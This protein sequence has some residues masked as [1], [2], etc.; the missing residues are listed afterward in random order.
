MKEDTACAAALPTVRSC[1]GVATCHTTGF[2]WTDPGRPSVHSLRPISS[3]AALSR[4][5]GHLAWIVEPRSRN[6]LHWSSGLQSVAR[7]VAPVAADRPVPAARRVASGITSAH[8]HSCCNCWSFCRKL[9]CLGS[10]ELLLLPLACALADGFRRSSITATACPQVH[11]ATP[12]FR[13]RSS[14]FPP[15]GCCGPTAD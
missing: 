8:V 2:K 6:H 12:V 5:L 11:S 14:G 4:S 3:L 15:F 9:V 10:Q 13:R 1:V 7:G